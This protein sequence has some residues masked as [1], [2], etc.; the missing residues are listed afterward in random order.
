MYLTSGSILAPSRSH[1]GWPDLL[2]VQLREQGLVVRDAHPTTVDRGPEWREREPGRPHLDAGA[3]HV[4]DVVDAAGQVRVR[5]EA[6][7]AVAVSVE[8]GIVAGGGTVDVEQGVP[9]V[10]HHDAVGGVG[11]GHVGQRVQVSSPDLHN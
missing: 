8:P 1:D 6:V 10:R 9:H 5:R 2:D 3:R 4:E 7:P 11:G